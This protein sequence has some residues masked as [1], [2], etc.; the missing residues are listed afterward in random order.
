MTKILNF[1]EFNS[2]SE[3]LNIQ[4]VSK[5]RL[6]SVPP[7][8]KEEEEWFKKLVAG[9]KA[10]GRYFKENIKRVS[11]TVIALF[12]ACVVTLVI[13]VKWTSYF[14]MGIYS[15]RYLFMI[16]PL[17]VAVTVSV[18]YMFFV[19]IIRNKKA[20]A[21]ILLT[22]SLGLS[23]LSHFMPD[24]DAFFFKHEEDGITFAGL[25]D[26][27]QSIIVFWADWIISP[28]APE[29]MHT[30]KY[31]ATT[32]PQYKS[33]DAF[34]DVDRTKPVYLLVDQHYILP[35]G[36]TYE[37]ARK[38]LFYSAAGDNLYTEDDFLAFYRNLD[39]IDDVEYVGLDVA[40][41]REFKIYRLHFK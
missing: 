41:E 10:K 35:E 27:A 32:Y 29:I 21:A 30:G 25:E 40:Y 20:V 6:N 14:Y 19:W 5:D 8:I 3:K 38:V 15:G 39:Y 11:F 9:L 31:Y 1:K 26:D 23:V 4:P 2:V 18:A 12:L 36:M 24:A 37:E 13:V 16:Y 7:F 28:L 34:A 22:L 33:E 17:I